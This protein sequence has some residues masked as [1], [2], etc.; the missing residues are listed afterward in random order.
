MVSALDDNILKSYVMLSGKFHWNDIYILGYA[1]ALFI[2]TDGIPV[3]K[4]KSGTGQLLSVDAYPK[5]MIDEFSDST[6]KSKDK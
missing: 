3:N 5:I 6:L 4:H 2:T 1:F